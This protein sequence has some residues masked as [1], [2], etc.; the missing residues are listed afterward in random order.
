[1][2]KEVKQGVLLQ[3]YL[4]LKSIIMKI[5][6]SIEG[7]KIQVSDGYHTFDEL[8]RHRQVLF[9]ALCNILMGTKT[10]YAWKSRVHSDWIMFDWMFIMWIG[11]QAGKII[12]Y[13]LDS[14]YRGL[15]NVEELLFAPERDWHT[16][17]DVLTRLLEL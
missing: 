7:W 16:S 13:H 11:N 8:Y 12:T 6:L 5:E 4:I 14:I 1:M 2:S 15:C 17:D 3:G 10:K 9:I